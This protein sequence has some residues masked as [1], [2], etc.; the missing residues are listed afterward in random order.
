MSKIQ[1]AGDV[2]LISGGFFG[3]GHFADCNVY[4]VNCGNELVLIDSGAGIDIGSLV[5]NVRTHGFD[6]KNITHV[7]LT[8]CHYDHTGG[9]KKIRGIAPGCNI[10]IGEKGAEAVEKGDLERLHAP[11]KYHFEQVNV[12]RRLRD[13]DSLKIGHHE[14][15]VISTP[16]HSND[17]ICFFLEHSNKRILFSGD[18]V[19]ALGQ[20]GAMSIESDFRAHRESLERISKLDIDALFPGHGIYIL[21]DAF[22]HVALVLE[23]LSGRWSDFLPYPSHPFWPRAMIERKLKS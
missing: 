14:F 17:G 7:L 1:L 20:L 16:G 11:R 21:S 15:R 10:L 9:C 13:N 12:T 19:L 2:Y 8:H 18:S 22:E 3:L 4:L 23:K 6:E 5:D